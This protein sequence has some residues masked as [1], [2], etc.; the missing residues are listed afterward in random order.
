MHWF[1]IRHN[2]TFRIYWDFVIILMACWN[3]FTLPIEIAFE[4]AFFRSDSTKIFNFMI[5]SCFGID[6][7]V[8]FLT[9]YQNTSG[10]EMV[11]PSRIAINYIKGRFWIDLLSTIP[12]DAAGKI[13]ISDTNVTRNFVLI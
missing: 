9:T 12:F 2:A 7:I 4:P 10:D 5:D 1:I 3:S 13:L 6:I 8:N 11:E